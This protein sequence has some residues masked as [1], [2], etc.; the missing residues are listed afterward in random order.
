M[1]LV[2]I[3]LKELTPTSSGGGVDIFW[4]TI[5]LF[6]VSVLCINCVEEQIIKNAL[7]LFSI[8]VFIFIAGTFLL[9]QVRLW[10]GASSAVDGEALVLAIQA[11]GASPTLRSRAHATKVAVGFIFLPAHTR[12]RLHHCHS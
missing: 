3:H 5:F 4:V 10:G 7:F 6:K 2:D 8:L 9:E 11:F 12:P 1:D